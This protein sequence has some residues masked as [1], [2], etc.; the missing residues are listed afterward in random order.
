MSDVTPMK[1]VRSVIKFCVSANMTPVDTYKFISRGKTSVQCSLVYRWHKRFTDG[2]TG[3]KDK[4]RSGRPPALN[5][6]VLEETI[7]QDRRKTVRELGVTLGVSKTTVHKT[8]TEDLKMNKVSARWVP[9]LLRDEEKERRVQTSSE[10]LERVEK[11]GDTFLHR[12]ITMDE[13]YLYLYEPETKQESMI[14]KHTTSP[15]PK[16]A[17]TSRSAKKFMFIFWMDHEGIL[18]SHVVPAAQTVNADYYQK[19]S[20][21][22]LIF[23]YQSQRQYPN[24]MNVL[25]V[26]TTGQNIKTIIKFIEVMG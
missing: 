8:L 19:V 5:E 10:F 3:V 7:N 20:Y 18:L 23:S 17:R 21:L 14:W 22:H 12:I 9:R 13:T 2:E 4:K 6:K 16:K 1:D 15:P 26:Y 11:E 25:K 24:N